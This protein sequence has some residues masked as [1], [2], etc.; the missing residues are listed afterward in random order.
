MINADFPD[1]SIQGE[2]KITKKNKAKKQNKNN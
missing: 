2:K 1:Y